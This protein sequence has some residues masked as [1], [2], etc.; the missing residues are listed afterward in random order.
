MRPSFPVRLPA[1][2]GIALG[3]ILFLLAILGIIG[4]VMSAGGSGGFSSAGIT[5]RIAA[6]VPSQ[7]NLIRAK[8]NECI[9]LY[10]SSTDYSTYPQAAS[11]TLVSALTCPG[12]PGTNKNMWTGSHPASLPPPTTGFNEWNYINANASGS[13]GV[14]IWVEPK[15]SSGGVVAGLTRTANKFTHAAANDGSAEVNYDSTKAKQRF[16]VWISTPPAVGAEDAEC[17]PQ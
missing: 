10:G 8:I 1:D 15:A 2:A 7:T 5:D 12:D 17:K 6:D 3:P 9:L 14:C 13:G 16:I 11:A 4:V